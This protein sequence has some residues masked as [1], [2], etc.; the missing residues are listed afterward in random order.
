MNEIYISI[1]QRDTSKKIRAKAYSNAAT[2]KTNKRSQRS[3][4]SVAFEYEHATLLLV[5]RKSN[6]KKTRKK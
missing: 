2:E 4:T 1:V 5:E 3:Q 6:K